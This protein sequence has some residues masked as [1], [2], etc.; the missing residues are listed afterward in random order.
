MKKPEPVAAAPVWETAMKPAFSP[1]LA[2]LVDAHRAAVARFEATDDD[3]DDFI[4]ASRT[5]DLARCD[6]AMRPCVS[7]EEFIEKLRYL[8]STEVSL[9]DEPEFLTEFGSVLIAVR[10]HLDRMAI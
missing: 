8:L 5:E 3:V 9:W 4:G 7:D 6:V 2:K 10:E 1:A